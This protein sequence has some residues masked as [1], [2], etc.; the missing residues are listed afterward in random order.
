GGNPG[1]SPEEADTWTLGVV[2]Q[3]S[4]LPRFNASIDYYSIEIEGLVGTV[5]ALNTVN[6]CYFNNIASACALIT[7]DGPTGSLW[8]GTGQVVASSPSIGGFSP[9]GGAS[10]ANSGADLAGRGSGAYGGL[11][12]SFV[13]TWL[14]ERITDTGLGQTNSVYDC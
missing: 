3:P 9:P 2:F 13:G 8:L 11:R 10:G 6:D 7:R 1:L 12:F 14:R 5:G 4:F